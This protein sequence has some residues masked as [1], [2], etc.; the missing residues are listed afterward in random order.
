MT[1]VSVS[2][3]KICDAIAK[4]PTT[5]LEGGNWFN[6]NEEGETTL[7]NCSVCAVGAVMRNAC[8]DRRQPAH[9]IEDAALAATVSRG[10]AAHSDETPESLAADRFYMNALSVFFER[11]YN[12]THRIWDLQGR[13]RML[14][15]KALKVEC[16]DF[17]KKNFPPKIEI[18]IDGA[19]PAKDVKVVKT[20]ETL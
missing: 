15:V 2:R 10:V 12:Y 17:V 6:L 16:I 20:K 19:K 8:L 9:A 7:T 1:V 3:K 11:G 4:E 13:S 18:Y 14:A 5:A